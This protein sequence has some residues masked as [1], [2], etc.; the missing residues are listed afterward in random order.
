MYI[1]NDT[2]I[3]HINILIFLSNHIILLLYWKHCSQCHC[4]KIILTLPP[5]EAPSTNKQLDV[6]EFV[7]ASE[8]R[9]QQSPASLSDLDL[10]FIGQ[11]FNHYVSAKIQ[12]VATT[13][14]D[15]VVTNTV[16][17][18]DNDSDVFVQNKK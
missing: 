14:D 10:Q 3:K 12:N 5:W 13:S 9:V 7:I 4:L 8:S 11:F 2:N 6:I 17:D 15:Q 16:V 1:N 18:L